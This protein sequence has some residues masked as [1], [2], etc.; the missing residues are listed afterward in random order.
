MDHE[1]IQELLGAFALDAVDS[2]EARVVEEHLAECPRCRAE[3][4]GHFEVAGALGNHVDP[5]PGHLWQQ[6]A[7]GI[8]GSE[9]VPVADLGSEGFARLVAR[10]D[11]L[12]G[13]ERGASAERVRGASG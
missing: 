5:V 3:V 13:T 12:E 9:R 10:R 6:I 8:E 4:D 1:Q 2:D 11:E 7:Q